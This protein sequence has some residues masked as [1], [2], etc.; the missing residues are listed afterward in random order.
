M[1]KTITERIKKLRKRRDITQTEMAKKLSVTQSTYAH[2]ERGS[3]DPTYTTF[4]KICQIFDVSADYLLGLSDT[5]KH[6]TLES[7]RI[8]TKGLSSFE[9][10]IIAYLIKT[11]KD[12]NENEHPKISKAKK[13]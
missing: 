7:I 13:N 1:D 10:E 6:I 5:K 4:I 9:Q 2:Y 3:R 12:N 8:N 11:F